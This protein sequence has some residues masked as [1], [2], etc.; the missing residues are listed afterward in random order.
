[1]GSGSSVLLLHLSDTHLGYRQYGVFEREL[2][3]YDVF[4][5]SIEL[6]LR[7]HVDLVVHAGDFFD[8]PRPPPQALRNAIRVLGLLRDR[9]I[10][11]LVVM[12]DHDLPRRR[13]LPPLVI[14]EDLGLAR[15]IGL[16]GPEKATVRLRAGSVVAAGF[17]AIRGPAARQRVREALSR[18][19][20]ARSSTGSGL[21]S[22][23]VLHQ[24]LR[25]ALAFDYELDVSTLPSGFQY[26]A[27]GHV[28]LH[29]VWRRDG[30]YVV[31]PGSPEAFRRD[32]AARQRD[33]YV[34][35]SEINSREA[36]SVQRL[37]LTRA[38][39]QPV[40]VVGYEGSEQFTR[41]LAGL[42][43]VLRASNGKK[44]LVHLK[45]MGVPAAAR[46]RVRELVERVLGDR[47][48]AYRLEISHTDTIEVREVKADRPAPDSINARE[49][50]AALLNDREL[51]ELGYQLIEILGSDSGEAGSVSEALQ[52]VR[53]F[54]GIED[55]GF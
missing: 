52:L 41:F 29:Y 37:K 55:E 53:R 47:V 31:Y 12:G 50:L 10:P 44:P 17:S 5:E 54:Y 6:A 2:D 15:I 11:F 13:M 28:H 3:V 9:G 14:L 21:P 42:A 46:Q 48:L 49:I 7:E 25:E 16:R 45:V 34:V 43:S 20:S 30:G 27:M 51:A 36:L 35:V 18:L 40:Y 33:R 26:Y 24:G 23:L 38:R 1:M 19:A 4:E 22:I 39:P 8:S 32:E